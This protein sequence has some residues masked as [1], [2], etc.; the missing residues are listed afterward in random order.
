[1][2]TDPLLSDLRRL[3]GA[4]ARI[5]KRCGI[6]RS[7]VSQWRKVPDDRLPDVLEVAREMG[8]RVDAP[9]KGKAA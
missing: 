5:A 6:T 7:A 4:T 1:M 8:V 9:R 3:R 2:A